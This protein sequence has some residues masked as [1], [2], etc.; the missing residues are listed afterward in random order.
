M[1]TTEIY[2]D[3]AHFYSKMHIGLPMKMSNQLQGYMLNEWISSENSIFQNILHAFSTIRVT[4][5]TENVLKI[6][7]TN[8]E[9]AK[10]PF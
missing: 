2:T 3:E 4:V 5:Y 10:R 7:L 9:Y 6:R 8:A 1:L